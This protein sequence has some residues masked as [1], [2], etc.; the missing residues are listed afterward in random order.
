MEHQKYIFEDF[1]VI[2]CN[3]AS[4]KMSYFKYI[5]YNIILIY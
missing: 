1:F 5:Y 4:Q 2:L 3:F